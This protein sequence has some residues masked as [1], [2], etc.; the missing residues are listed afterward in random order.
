MTPPLRRRGGRRRIEQS[1]P[2]IDRHRQDD[3]HH[4]RR[5]T[6]RPACGCCDA[7]SPPT[8]SYRTRPETCQ[9]RLG[10]LARRLWADP[11]RH[12]F[13]YRVNG[14][15]SLG[16]VVSMQNRVV[17]LNSRREGN[18]LRKAMAI[19]PRWNVV[20]RG[21]F[22]Q[23]AA[24]HWTNEERNVLGFPRLPQWQEVDRRTVACRRPQL[25]R[26]G[27]GSFRY[28]VSAVTPLA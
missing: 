7:G 4:R 22:R 20:A 5:T 27:H 11:V 2:A 12:N 23:G 1:S 14:I 18:Q 28:A 13:M 19:Q 17:H 9:I 24:I 6:A 25:Y 15:S 21:F 26:R 16:N 10:R 8:G 3:F